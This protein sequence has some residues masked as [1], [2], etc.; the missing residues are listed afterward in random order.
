[1]RAWPTS[2]VDVLLAEPSLALQPPA[3]WQPVATLAFDWR[4][5]VLVVGRDLT[6]RDRAIIERSGVIE[7]A[8]TLQGGLTRVGEA[9]W[10]VVVVAPSIADESDGLRFVR[11]CKC[12][13]V[14][15]GGSGQLEQLRERYGRTPFLVQPLEGDTQF[16]IFHSSL[17]WYLGNTSAVPLAEAILRSVGTP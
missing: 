12:S 15:V 2:D 14:L 5:S 16:A 17:R 10:D 3:P 7:F 8:P 4:P 1:M 6:K 9:R 11:A 13:S